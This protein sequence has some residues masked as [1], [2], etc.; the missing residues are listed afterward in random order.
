MFYVLT[1][2]LTIPSPVLS[3]GEAWCVLVGLAGVRSW[4]LTG[5]SVALGQ[6]IGFALIYLFGGQIMGRVGKIRRALDAFDAERFREKAPWFLA[7]G[8]LTGLPPLLAMCVL[9]P[10]VGIPLGRL[11][12]LTLT[13]R[14]VRFCV[15]AGAPYTFSQ[16]FGTGW[17][18]TWLTDL[19]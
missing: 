6:T 10:A 11:L 16:Y 8:A 5:F 4:W 13:L 17:L 19:I 14:T 15:L 9:A 3:Y 2:V 18:P 1:V 12:A 7:V